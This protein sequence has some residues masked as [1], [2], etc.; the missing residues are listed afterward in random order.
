MSQQMKKFANG[1]RNNFYQQKN[2]KLRDETK[3]GKLKSIV[4]FV[5]LANRLSL[6]RETLMHGAWPEHIVMVPG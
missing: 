4:P 2:K 5:K 1:R 3:R 6:S